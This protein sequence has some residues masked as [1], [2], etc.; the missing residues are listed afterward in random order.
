MSRAVPEID[1]DKSM[2]ALKYEY[3][4]AYETAV[5][6]NQILRPSTH[7]EFV[8]AIAL[9]E[10]F[11]VH[12]R[13]LHEFFAGKGRFPTDLRAS[14]FVLGYTDT[15]YDTTTIDSINRA[16]QHLTVYR[17]DG[18]IPWYPMSMLEMLVAA[19]GSPI[20]PHARR[21]PIHCRGPSTRPR[22]TRL[23]S[24][25]SQ[26]GPG[27]K[28]PSSLASSRGRNLQ[29]RHMCSPDHSRYL[30]LFPLQRR[31]HHTTPPSASTPYKHNQ[32]HCMRA[33]CSPHFDIRR[34]PIGK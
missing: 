22:D 29:N 25:A 8:L 18:H 17:Q 34:C 10:S 24:L 31:V 9:L 1:L 33:E 5:R 13:L 32:P 4:M 21:E 19:M 20:A 11:L 2:A 27:R 16:L 6:A 12:A 23:A 14:D 26:R 15:V 3:D 7:D 28:V 30:G